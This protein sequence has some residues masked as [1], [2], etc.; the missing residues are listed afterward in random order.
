MELNS[1]LNENGITTDNWEKANLDFDLLVEIDNDYRKRVDDLNSNAEFLAKL[2]QKC[3]EV[4]SVR[5]RVKEPSHVLEKI[6]RKRAE[7]PSKYDDVSVDN[8]MDLITDLVGVRVLH[9]FK[10]EWLDIHKYITG[11]WKPVEPVTAYIRQGDEGSLTSNY[12]ENSCTVKPHS[13]GYRSIHYIVPIQL[14][15]DKILSEIQV[16]TIFEEG[17]SEIDHKIRYPNFSNNELIKYFLTIFNRMA[18]SADEMGTFVKELT[19]EISLY[20]LKHREYEKKHDDHLSTME[21]L[22]SDLSKEREQNRDH[23]SSLK[24]LEDEIKELRA[25]T[26]RSSR[27]SIPSLNSLAGVDINTLRKATNLPALDLNSLSALP[28]SSAQILAGLDTGH[29]GENILYPS[30]LAREALDSLNAVPVKF[31]DT[32]EM[33]DNQSIGSE[34]KKDSGSEEDSDEE[35]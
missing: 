29:L 28:T 24:K 21:S 30:S 1:F 13:A 3:K 26:T 18:G 5:W 22:A 8:Y 4:H 19:T 34:D 14:T 35:T 10:N 23:A 32:I 16:R 17:W 33:N 31:P 2:L 9:L 25:S 20:E 7:G 12:E 15:A 6:V 11:K 27:L